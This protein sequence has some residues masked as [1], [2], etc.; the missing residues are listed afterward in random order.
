M[1]SFVHYLFSSLSMSR[2]PSASPEDIYQVPDDAVEFV[3]DRSGAHP[4]PEEDE[5]MVE[6][7]E[8]WEPG[9]L[10]VANLVPAFE[11]EGFNGMEVVATLRKKKERLGKKMTNPQYHNQDN[12]IID[13]KLD[14]MAVVDELGSADKVGASA[15]MERVFPDVL[16]TC[17]AEVQAI[18][19]DDVLA[20]LL[21]HQ[22]QKFA[23]SAEYLQTLSERMK[24]A[25]SFD[26]VL[27]KKGLALL[28]AIGRVNQEIK[29]TN[30]M[31]TFCGG[32]VHTRPDGSRWGVLANI[33]DSGAYKQRANG[34][35]IPLFHED[36]LLEI[37]VRSRAL[38][39]EQLNKHAANPTEP[40]DLPINKA[41]A[42]AMGF[43][44][45]DAENLERAGRV[46]RITFNKELK[47]N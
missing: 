23:G 21:E 3:G 26:L 29:D 39:P 19:K 17:L 25:V 1:L 46:Q 8:H 9:E 10:Q 32:F 45:T 42:M 12:I 47:P 30:S 31:T 22:Q 14:F 40:F 2:E 37:V 35:T 15:R 34:E 6:V 41:I 44:A 11:I 4:L 13:Q 24:Q 28:R 20:E 16:K 38:S 18:S 33:G 7:R 36:A 27:A 5:G 43:S